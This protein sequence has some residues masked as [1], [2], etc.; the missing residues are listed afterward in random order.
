MEESI[1]KNSLIGTSYEKN[2]YY[3]S[4]YDIN[5]NVIQKELISELLFSNEK[6]NN[7]NVMNMDIKNEAFCF[8]CKKNINFNMNPDCK[9]HN[10]KYLNDLIKDINI[11]QI[12]KDLEL[13]IENYENVYRIIEEKLNKFKK[14]NENQILLAKKIIELYKTNIHNLNYQMISNTKNL[15]HFKEIRLTDYEDYN[16]KFILETNIL[17]EYSLNN[18]IYE[19]LNIQKIQKNTEIKTDLDLNI[20]K[21]ILLKNQNKIIFNTSKNI[22]LLNNKNYLIED[23]IETN[24][25]I[26]SINFIEEKMILISFKNS[27]KKLKIENDKIMIENFLNNIEVSEPGIIIKYKDEYAWTNGEHIQFSNTKTYN[28]RDD[29]G[30]EY[31]DYE[32]SYNLKVIN[33]I[34]FFD[35]IL[36]IFSIERIYKTSGD[37]NFM[38]G[39]YKKGLSKGNYICLEEF[40]FNGYP[41][42]KDVIYY[43]YMNKDY[44]IY[45]YNFGEI[46]V[47]GKLGIYF[48][49]PCQWKIKKEIIFSNKLIENALYLNK[50]YFLIFLRKYLFKKKFYRFKNLRPEFLIINNEYNIIIAKIGGNFSQI[51]F[52]TLIDY[53]GRKIYYSPDITDNI[54]NLV[55]QFILVNK[56][57]ISVY[58]LINIQKKIEMINY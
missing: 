4:I 57:N 1:L 17:E 3:I 46:I 42:R 54:Y 20:E 34:Q 58:E 19:N 22:F 27:I 36:F 30:S 41:D 37:Y 55:N 48:I 25:N 44:N 13:A 53:E 10:I 14:R 52:R 18:Y 29:L 35:D 5:K 32:S 23:K 45:I 26:L 50:F 8:D 12:E 9:T 28:Y 47:I 6:I 38:L 2:N 33:L 40:D 7:I 24:D 43:K 16:S 11:E 56:E 51:I 49:N 15:L 21:V 39:S 31:F